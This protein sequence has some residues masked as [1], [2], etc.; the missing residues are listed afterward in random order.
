MSRYDFNSRGKNSI[1]LY[2]DKSTGQ[3]AYFDMKIKRD[4]TI[5]DYPN[6]EHFLQCFEFVKRAI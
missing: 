4:I 1:T 2:Y 3:L 6:E 5:V